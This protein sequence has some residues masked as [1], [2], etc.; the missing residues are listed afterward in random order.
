MQTDKSYILVRCVY[1]CNN[2]LC[3]YWSFSISKDILFL[4]LYSPDSIII[5]MYLL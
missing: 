3:I 1:D 5:N 4:Y 2:I